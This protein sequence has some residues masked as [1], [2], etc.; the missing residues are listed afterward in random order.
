MKK[1]V[2]AIVLVL[3]C[4][5]GL[6]FTARPI[7]RFEAQFLNVFDT[8]SKIIGYSKSRED[9]TEMVT[10]M[11]KELTEYH[12]LYDIYN[13]YPGIHNLKTVNDQAGIQPVEVDERILDLLEFSKQA[14][15]LT[16]GKVNVACGSVLSLWHEA[17]VKG[18]ND[19]LHA[20]LPDPEALKEAALHTRM[21]DVVIDREKG[22]VFLKDP[23]MR[24]DVGA[25]AKGYAVEQVCLS[26]EQAGYDHVLLSVGGNVRA[27]GIRGDGTKWV[28]PVESPYETAAGG[29]LCTVLLD[30]MSL[31]SSGDYQRYYTVDGETYHH[32]I[33]PDTLMPAGY[34]RAV[35]VLCRDSG[36]ADTLTT[37]L[38]LM[39]LEE[40]QKLVEAMDGVEAVWAEPDGDVLYSSGFEK[41]LRT[42]Q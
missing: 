32:I 41:Y 42:E 10:L 4:F 14:Y 1:R 3:L 16:D 18:T 15:E 21:E 37:G 2:L 40:G 24:L 30:G 25:V 35:T 28:V 27:V 26:M 36:L 8:V 19:P 17:R 38:F 5:V 6:A 9:F 13:E 33:D 22:T 29:Y 23:E 11:E 7:K 34:H 12:Q 39:T 31:I 20:S